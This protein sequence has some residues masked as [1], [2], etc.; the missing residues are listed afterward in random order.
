MLGPKADAQRAPQALLETPET[1]TL[2]FRQRVWARLLRL[3]SRVEL[4]WDRIVWGAR[5]HLGKLGPLQVVTYRGYGRNGR[6]LLR[7]RVLEA[8]VLERSL[9]VDTRWQSFR[10]MLRR[11]NSREVPEA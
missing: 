8:S 1:R 10:R 4:V 9:P 6:A 3:L 2:R 11:F 7:G 5:R